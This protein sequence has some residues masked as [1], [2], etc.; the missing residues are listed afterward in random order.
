MNY[1]HI[2]QYLS[3]SNRSYN[4]LFYF[5]TGSYLGLSSKILLLFQSLMCFHFQ[6]CPQAAAIDCQIWIVNTPHHLSKGLQIYWKSVESIGRFE[7]VN[8]KC[9]SLA[10]CRDS[11]RCVLRNS[12]WSSKSKQVFLRNTV[13]NISRCNQGQSFFM[14]YV[15]NRI[16]RFFL[17]Q[18]H[19]F[20]APQDDCCA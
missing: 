10:I 20:C 1:A 18:W 9:Q 13:G 2:S 6:H 17:A 3:I 11:R 5:R 16:L 4:L 7:K 8:P 19:R 12:L 15:S 14:L